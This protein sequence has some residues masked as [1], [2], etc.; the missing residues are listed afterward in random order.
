[1]VPRQLEKHRSA[2][3]KNSANPEPASFEE[4][5]DKESTDSDR[6]SPEPAEDHWS[7]RRNCAAY[8]E[9]IFSQKTA[10]EESTYR[11]QPVSSHD[12]Q[13]TWKVEGQDT[14]VVKN[15]ETSDHTLRSS[16]RTIEKRSRTWTISAPGSPTSSLTNSDSSPSS[17]ASF[18][19]TVSDGES[20]PPQVSN[21]AW[22]PLR[23]V[24]ALWFLWI[25]AV[26]VALFVANSPRW[27]Y[28][29]YSDYNVDYNGSVFAKAAS[30]VVSSLPSIWQE[31][32]DAV[33]GYFES[34]F[35]LKWIRIAAMKAVSNLVLNL[36][37]I[38][39]VVAGIF[40]YKIARKQIA[41]T[42][43]ESLSNIASTWE[44]SIKAISEFANGHLN[45]RWIASVAFYTAV[46]AEIFY[47]QTGYLTGIWSH[48]LL[49]RLRLQNFVRRKIGLQEDTLR[50]H[51]VYLDLHADEDEGTVRR[52]HYS[53][54]VSAFYVPFVVWT[55]GQ[56]FLVEDGPLMWEL[57]R[58][59]LF[60]PLYLLSI[61]RAQW[62]EGWDVFVLLVGTV[63][64][65]SKWP[66]M[67]L[68]GLWYL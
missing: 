11:R 37:D 10:E 66:L 44:E 31:A 55:V 67:L 6:P 7:A 26:L 34:H 59:K 14:Y 52:R 3:R 36:M 60:W 48:V 47:Y 68:G 30:N 50:P 17:K 9:P 42:F 4:V 27:S 38:M 40:G 13:E 29:G 15:P 25:L 19:S 57:T 2:R 64:G 28:S 23:W 32:A 54:R 46:I 45:P 35:V 41:K 43:S 18:G 53:W 51:R 62:L 21:H 65:V 22:G 16:P 56:Y 33:A 8:P 63:L 49:Y 24:L 1:M 58:R 5:V 12:W 20:E 39:E 61:W